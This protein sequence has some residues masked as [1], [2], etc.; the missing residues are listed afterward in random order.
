MMWIRIRNTDEFWQASE[1]EDLKE[2]SLVSVQ[3]IEC[4]FVPDTGI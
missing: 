2:F 1:S 4:P 3:L